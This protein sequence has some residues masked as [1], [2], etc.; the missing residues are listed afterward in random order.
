[1]NC[2]EARKRWHLLLDDG[3]ADPQLEQHLAAC[4]ECRTYSRQL[5]RVLQGLD[6][7]RAESEQI[8]V[9]DSRA[10][11]SAFRPAY[12]PRWLVEGMRFLRVAA[13][14]AFL[15][16]GGWY[17]GWHLTD[18]ARMPDGMQIVPA[19][20]S[21]VST[22]RTASFKLRGQTAKDYLAVQMP[23]PEPN[24]RVVW[25]YPVLEDPVEDG[26]S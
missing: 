3:R 22:G 18:S 6:A 10:S 1:M 8:A 9:L 19:V 15:V 17:F 16:F 2:E 20:S 23:A 13:A 7:L 24:V 5:E 21:P 4:D 11:E 14:L 25:L 26:D 12:A